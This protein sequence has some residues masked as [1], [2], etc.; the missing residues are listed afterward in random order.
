MRR[1]LA[2]AI[3]G[4]LALP[5]I[6]QEADPVLDVRPA[7]DIVLEDFLWLNR[8]IIVFANSDRDPSFREQ[9]ELLAERS[10]RHK[11]QGGQRYMVE[12][13]VKEGKGGLRDLQ[14]LFWIGKYIHGVTD[15]AELVP[16]GLF[17]QEEFDRFVTA[18]A[19]GT[20]LC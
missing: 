6:A 2:I 14:T 7:D 10:D 15:A 18:E 16:L 13:N 11:R 1:L 19:C 12:P 17:R 8:L 4:C 3:A 5:V 9:M 20:V